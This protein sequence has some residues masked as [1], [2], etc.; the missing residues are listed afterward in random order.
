MRPLFP[1]WTNTLRPLLAAAA[2]GGG[3]YLVAVVTLGFSPKATDVGYR[4]TQPVP[5]SHALHN[6]ELGLDCRY[7]HNTVERAAHAAVP[8]TETCMA[9]HA[10][11]HTE[12][13]KLT[14][15]RESWATGE[16]VAWKKVHDLPDYVYFD[17]SAHVLGGVACVSCHGR[18]DRMEIVHQDKPLSMGWCLDCHRDPTPN[19]RPPHLVTAMEA[20]DA[21]DPEVRAFQQAAGDRASE[22]CSTCHR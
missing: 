12:S 16:P 18:V 13:R 20:V 14:A 9:C 7:C 10:K 4:P 5:F 17:H 2:I 6:G 1:P 21:T 22:D 11:I 3:L 19:L 15:V 8:T